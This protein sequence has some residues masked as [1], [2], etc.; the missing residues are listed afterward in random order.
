MVLE[1]LEHAQCSCAREGVAGIRAS[2]T[3]GRDGVQKL[4]PA[5]YSGEGE[6]AAEGLGG[7]DQVRHDA[8]VVAGEHVA[9]PT[10]PGL[11]LIGHQD[12]AVT[13]RECG[14]RGQEAGGW[15][16]EATFTLQRLDDDCRHAVGADLFE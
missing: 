14:D 2:Q 10:E 9:S 5:G 16:D 4:G 7:A 8:L 12:D 3:T 1:D 15:H 13:R 6:A 11:D